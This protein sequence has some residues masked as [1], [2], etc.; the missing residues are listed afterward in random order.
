MAPFPFCRSRTAAARGGGSD[1]TLLPSRCAQSVSRKY[2]SCGWKGAY[3]IVCVYY[4]VSAYTCVLLLGK[5]KW[6]WVGEMRPQLHALQVHIYVEPL[7]VVLMWSRDQ[8]EI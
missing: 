5:G 6:A 3:S 2:M 8:F 1:A 7:G 4:T